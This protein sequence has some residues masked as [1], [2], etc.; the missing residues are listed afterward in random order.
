M[1]RRLWTS[2]LGLFGA[3]MI[4][5]VWLAGC[6]GNGLSTTHRQLAA[7]RL[8]GGQMVPP[9]ATAAIGTATVTVNREHDRVVA[10]RRE[11]NLVITVTGSVE[12]GKSKVAKIHVKD[13][14]NSTDYDS[15]D[16]VPDRY[17]EKVKHLVALTQ[18]E[19]GKIEIKVKAKH[20]AK[21]KDKDEDNNEDEE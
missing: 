20:R 10:R 7:T 3:I 21:D 17:R 13:E 16:A 8:S 12:D 18:E 14:K 19:G 5:A 2:R 9:V 15:V 1:R 6:G 4:L 11:G